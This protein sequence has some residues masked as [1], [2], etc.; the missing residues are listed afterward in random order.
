MA[1]RNVKE[2]MDSRDNVG[3]IMKKKNCRSVERG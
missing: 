3:F 1:A 2:K